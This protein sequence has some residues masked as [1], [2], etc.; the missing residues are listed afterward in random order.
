M[1]TAEKLLT[2][3]EFYDLPT[4]PGC[5]KME[6]WDGEVVTM[7][8]VGGEHGDVAG[9]LVSALRAFATKAGLGRAG[10]EVGYRLRQDPDVVLAPDISFTEGARLERGRFPRSYVEGPPTLAVEVVSP[11]DTD[12]EVARKVAA[13]LEAGAERV[14]VVRPAQKSVTVHWPGGDAH[15]YGAGEMLGSREAG[16]TVEGFALAVDEVFG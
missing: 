11:S 13:Y 10:V 4:P 9:A 12:N 5:G 16:F 14:W 6:L 1:T 7:A 2:A 15:T 3:D 8:P